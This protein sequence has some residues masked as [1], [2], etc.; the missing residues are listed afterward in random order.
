V[1]RRHIVVLVMGFLSTAAQLRAQCDEVGHCAP[2]I[3]FIS[4]TSST[5]TFSWLWEV[6]LFQHK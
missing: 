2:L 5:I 6:A 4:A 3:T 1:L